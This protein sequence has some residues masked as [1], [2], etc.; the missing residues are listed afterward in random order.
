MSINVLH[1]SRK[2]PP[3]AERATHS[4]KTDFLPA[5][6]RGK[7]TLWRPG[8]IAY[9]GPSRLW[10]HSLR[11]L[12]QEGFKVRLATTQ[13][14]HTL[15]GQQREMNK[16]FIC[17]QWGFVL[18]TRW[19]KYNVYDNA[20]CVCC[21]ARDESLP[22]RAALWKWLRFLCSILLHRERECAYGQ[23]VVEENWCS[24]HVCKEVW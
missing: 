3:K 24:T 20:F 1:D 5:R 16:Y 9:T 23:R 17:I 13:H 18:E 22:Q 19:N 12:S 8:K 14:T 10:R 21:W 2:T 15:I 7:V 4:C 6:V 11:A